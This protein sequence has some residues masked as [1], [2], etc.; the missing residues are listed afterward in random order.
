[1]RMEN[2]TEGKIEEKKFIG[3]LRENPYIAS[4]IILGVVVLIL[5]F[6]VL[7]T[8]ITGEII[9]GEEAGNKLVEFLNNKVG[10]GV[11]YVSYEDLGNIY[12][13]TVLYQGQELPVYCTKDGKYFA[14]GIAPI[15]E[16]AIQPVEEEPQ[17]LVKSDKPKVELFVMS[18]CPYG[19]R[20]EDTMLPVYNLLKNKV[21]F[22]V[23][24]IVNVDGNNI[25]SLHGQPE[26][27]EDER[28]MCVL[29][30]YGKDKFWAF[31]TGIN[32]DC[33]SKGECWEDVAKKLGIDV[34]KVKT[35]V[36]SNGLNLMKIEADATDQAGASGSP[37]LVINGVKS[38]A[39]YQYGNSEAYKQA[40]CSAFNEIPEECNQQLSGSTSTS[41]GGS[42]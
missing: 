7:K 27:D 4:T 2:K 21:D 16:M 36:I 15:T 31:M 39:V 9:S 26:V 19:N 17:E 18:F 33:G 38:N 14:Q 22:I 28:E 8:G 41:T 42:C 3:K 1:M 23:H 37:T 6:V 40:I 5:F 13:I 11:N 35:C 29:K 34:N 25:G 32:K 30:D 12:E 10:G 24:Y 20:A